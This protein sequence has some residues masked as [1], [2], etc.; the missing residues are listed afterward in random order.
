MTYAQIRDAAV[1]TI[2]SGKLHLDAKSKT[3]INTVAEGSNPNGA[4]GAVAGVGAGIALAVVGIDSV[5]EICDNATVYQADSKTLQEVH[6]SAES[7]NKE[8]MNAKA[9]AAG[10]IAI[11]PVLALTISSV[12]NEAILGRTDRR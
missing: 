5:A 10:G 8:I 1:V 6:I 12:T 9:G 4:G 7:E 3:N 2:G 11:T